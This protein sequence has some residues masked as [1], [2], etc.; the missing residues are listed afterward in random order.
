MNTQNTNNS[1]DT[2]YTNDG[3]T[4]ITCNVF[5]G[6]LISNPQPEGDKH[7]VSPIITSNSVVMNRDGTV[8]FDFNVDVDSSYPGAPTFWVNIKTKEF[9]V[10]YNYTEEWAPQLYNWHIQA[11]YDNDNGSGGQVLAVG[12]EITLYNRD[13]D[14]ITSS[15]K[16]TTVQP[17][18]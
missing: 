18:A 15:G 1:D 12:D 3:M 11:T 14:P 9:Y 7:P 6:A 10:E 8:S 17:P 16:K 4:Q 13:V 2:P 5:R